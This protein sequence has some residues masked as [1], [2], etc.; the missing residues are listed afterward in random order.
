MSFDSRLLAGG[1]FTSIAGV[2]ADGIAAWDGITWQPLPPIGGSVQTFAIYENTLYAALYRRSGQQI[3]GA[4]MRWTGSVWEV[5]GAAFNAP[6]YALCVHDGSLIAAGAF[7]EVG[8]LTANRVARLS[9]SAWEAVGGGVNSYVTAMGSHGGDLIASGA[10]NSAEGEPAVFIA[11][12]D[13]VRWQSMAEGF[14]GSAN[15]FADL[16]GTLVVGGY[17]EYLRRWDGVQW[18]PFE[19]PVNGPVESLL[20]H[21]GRL[22]AAGSFTVAGDHVA[23][24]FSSWGPRCA[25][26]IDG[27]GLVNAVDLGRLLFHFGSHP[28]DCDDGDLNGDSAVG[29]GDLTILLSA[30]GRA[31]D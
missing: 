6:V 31:C 3:D 1:D 2:A 14:G 28:A 12:W 26:D 19:P 29:L 9:G 11:R 24:G 18:L 13:G 23:L 30:F 27:D 10:F 7:T 15:A 5:V 16:D 17:G 20:V 21:D 25:G 8:G 4:V 22:M